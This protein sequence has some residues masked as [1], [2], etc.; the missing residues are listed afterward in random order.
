MMHCMM[1]CTWH[2]HVALHVAGSAWRTTCHQGSSRFCALVGLCTTW[3]PPG[4]VHGGHV[5]F[6]TVLN[7]P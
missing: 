2:G 1:H 6:S 3:S 5:G 4:G 7:H